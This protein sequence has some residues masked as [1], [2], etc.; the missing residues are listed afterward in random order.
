MAMS[1]DREVVVV[2]GGVERFRVTESG[3]LRD[4]HAHAHTTHTHTH[5][6]CPRT[7]ARARS[8]AGRSG[9]NGRRAARP[10]PAGGAGLEAGPKQLT[11][12]YKSAL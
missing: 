11:M 10:G 1:N 7:V 6:R 2:G 8:P 3:G 9:C 12:N 4:I 5:T